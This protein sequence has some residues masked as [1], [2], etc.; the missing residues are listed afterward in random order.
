V[1]GVIMS[2]T[3]TLIT[4]RSVAASLLEK[5][6]LKTNPDAVI[7]HDQSCEPQTSSVNF[8]WVLT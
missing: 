2:L 4:Y 8:A 5:L 1:K 3:N 6:V 7:S